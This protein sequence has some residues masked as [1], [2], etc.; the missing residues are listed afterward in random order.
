MVLRGIL[1]SKKHLKHGTN[2][3]KKK[4]VSM[5]LDFSL[6]R[7][8][9]YDDTGEEFVSEVFSA[10]IT[11]NL[12]KM[13][14]AV[15]IYVPLWRPEEKGFTKAE[16]IIEIVE[17]GLAELKANPKKYKEY[18]SDNGWGLYINFVP[19]VE[20]VLKACKEYPKA[21]IDVSR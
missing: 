6:I 14:M 1:R 19:W 9:K 21:I 8:G 13:A 17:T 4:E 18:D 20:N 2:D 7:T 16:D 5:S 12:N 11:H 10:N 3:T 15:D